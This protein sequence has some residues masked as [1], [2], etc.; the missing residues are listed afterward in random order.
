MRFFLRSLLDLKDLQD[1]D[2]A[3]HEAMRG[4]TDAYRDLRGLPSQDQSNES[5]ESFFKRFEA[6]QTARSTHSEIANEVEIKSGRY[7]LADLES[8]QNAEKEAKTAAS[9]AYDEACSSLGIFGELAMPH[10]LIEDAISKG[11][12]D[13]AAGRAAISAK[14]D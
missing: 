4:M 1:G 10:L 5:I 2:P 11:G 13:S 9:L 12:D 6:F 8:S 3:T 7:T 14:R